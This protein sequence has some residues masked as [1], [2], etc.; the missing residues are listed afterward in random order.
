VTGGV[1]QVDQVVVAV[2]GHLQGRVQA[3]S[4]APAAAK[5][6][7]AGAAKQVLGSG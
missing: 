5:A 1:N 6:V 3:C 7:Q 4:S 2:P